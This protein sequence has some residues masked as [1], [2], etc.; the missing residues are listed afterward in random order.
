MF[1][2]RHPNYGTQVDGIGFCC[3]RSSLSTIVISV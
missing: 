3:H 1:E 2:Y